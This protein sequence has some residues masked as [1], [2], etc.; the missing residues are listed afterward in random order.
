MDNTIHYTMP[1]VAQRLSQHI[2]NHPF[3]LPGADTTSVLDLLYVA[4]AESLGRDPQE[5]E[6]GFLRLGERLEP[7]DL[8][9]NNAIFSIVCELCNAYEKRAFIDAVQLGAWFMLELQEK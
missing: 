6:Q 7:L 3:L 5:I 4:Y 9:E 2:R 8:G 1:T